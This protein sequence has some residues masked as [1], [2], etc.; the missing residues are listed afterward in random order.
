MNGRLAP[1]CD[2]LLLQ[3]RSS[4]RSKHSCRSAIRPHGGHTASVMGGRYTAQC[5][6][7]KRSGF[8]DA[9]MTAIHRLKRPPAR[10]TADQGYKS[11]A[12]HRGPNSRFLWAAQNL[13]LEAT[14]L[15]PGSLVVGAFS[16]IR[17]QGS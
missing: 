10:E 16:V 11:V 14:A 17:W 7:R 9:G 12:Q 1:K 3:P 13:F 4:E 5:T 8:P 2:G 6:S 15:D